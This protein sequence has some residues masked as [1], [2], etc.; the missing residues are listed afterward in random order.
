[1]Q[2]ISGLLFIVL[3]SGLPSVGGSKV[4]STS[5]FLRR[6]KETHKSFKDRWWLLNHSDDYDLIE[7]NSN[8]KCEDMNSIVKRY[9]DRSDGIRV[10][11][12]N[13]ETVP[14]YRAAYDSITK[15]FRARNIL[16]MYYNRRS[17]RILYGPTDFDNFRKWANGELS[18]RETPQMYDFHPIRKNSIGYKLLDK[19]CFRI[20]EKAYLSAIPS[21][22]YICTAHKTL[23]HCGFISFF[24]ILQLQILLWDNFCK[25]LSAT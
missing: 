7:F 22:K 23:K 4:F 20:I 16:P 14:H 25:A 19:V 18:Y 17:K 13:V 8:K 9:E 24:L 1:M 3:T 12:C 6:F 5:S 15:Y 11:R 21:C 2:W 10:L